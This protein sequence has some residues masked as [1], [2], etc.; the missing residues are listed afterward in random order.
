[1]HDANTV[2]LNSWCRPCKLLAPVLESAVAQHNGAV[3]LAKLNVDNN[4]SVHVEAIPAVFGYS[5]G[6]VVSQFVG[7][8]PSGYVNEFVANLVAT[9]NKK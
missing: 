1:M 8:H 4:R 6:K 3:S 2:F 7:A 9:H 5:K